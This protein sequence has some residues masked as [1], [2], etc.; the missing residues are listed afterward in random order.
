MPTQREFFNSLNQAIYLGAK[1]RLRDHPT[2]PQT[3]YF[4]FSSPERIP[5]P[6]TEKLSLAA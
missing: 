2:P 4:F 5:T 3:A 1:S 6:A